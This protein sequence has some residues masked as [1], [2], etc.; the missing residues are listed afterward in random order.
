MLANAQKIRIEHS[1]RETVA[2]IT[3]L[4]PRTRLRL[5]RM[6]AQRLSSAADAGALQKTTSKSN[7]LAR[8]AVGWN[9]VLGCRNVAVAFSSI[10]RAAVWHEIMFI[11]RTRSQRVN[12]N[13]AR[14][15]PAHGRALS[16][17]MPPC[18][19]HV[20]ARWYVR[21]KQEAHD[22]H[23]GDGSPAEVDAR[24]VWYAVRKS[25]GLGGMTPYQS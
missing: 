25:S 21:Y 2:N 17:Y 4:V 1:E 8:E 19:P 9:A 24:C 20:Y 12:G 15:V 13:A 22:A 7:D 11:C 14:Y 16:R 5:T 6:A 3:L 10:K 23:M 18:P